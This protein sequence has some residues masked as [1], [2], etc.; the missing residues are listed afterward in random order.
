M[1]IDA[2]QQR[3]SEYKKKQLMLFLWVTFTTPGEGMMRS[4]LLRHSDCNALLDL[5]IHRRE[6]RESRNLANAGAASILTGCA[7]CRRSRGYRDCGGW[8][9]V[10]KECVLVCTQCI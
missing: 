5:H 8:K 7:R 6:I 3:P 2:Y 4:P 10:G 1:R 9:G